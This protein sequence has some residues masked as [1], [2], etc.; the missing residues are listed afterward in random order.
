M[1]EYWLEFGVKDVLVKVKN[2]GE[3]I[4]GGEDRRFIKD[5][6]AVNEI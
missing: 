2:K 1:R 3:M 6:D 5:T 4:R